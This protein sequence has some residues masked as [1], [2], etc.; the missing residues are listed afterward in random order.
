MGE[1]ISI[2]KSSLF[3][4]PIFG[5]DDVCFNPITGS[6]EFS[7]VDFTKDN[8]KSNNSKKPQVYVNGNVTTLKKGNKVFHAKAEKGDN[9][10]LEKGVLVCVAKSAGWTTS[11]ILELIENAKI[12][13]KVEKKANKKKK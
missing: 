6:A 1:W 9:F 13:R 2:C 5:F 12:H 8:I 10:D 7:V 3:D 4:A 11:E